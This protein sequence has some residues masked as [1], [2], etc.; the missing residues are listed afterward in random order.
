MA[1]LQ[2]RN[3]NETIHMFVIGAPARDGA[4]SHH[5][6]VSHSARRASPVHQPGKQDHLRMNVAQM[7]KQSS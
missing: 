5:C 1:K 7:V 4:E 3:N 6:A 2:S